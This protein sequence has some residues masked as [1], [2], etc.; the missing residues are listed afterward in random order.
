MAKKSISFGKKGN[1]STGSSKL[2]SN[3]A[4]IDL[5]IPPGQKQRRDYLKS[6]AKFVFFSD[7]QEKYKAY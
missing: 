4:S 7:A 5:E 2:N 1:C 3:K 6:F